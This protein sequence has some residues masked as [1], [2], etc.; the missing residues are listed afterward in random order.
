[1]LGRAV[2]FT[3]RAVCARQLLFMLRLKT[4]EEKKKRFRGTHACLRPP[5]LY[6]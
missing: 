2:L 5:N 3:V 6:D 4:E 1:M